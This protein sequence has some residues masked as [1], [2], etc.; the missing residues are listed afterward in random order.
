MDTS[1]LLSDLQ[2]AFGWCKKAAMQQGYPHNSRHSEL[3]TGRTV[4]SLR[5]ADFLSAIRVEPWGCC[6]PHPVWDEGVF[7]FYRQTSP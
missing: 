6:T 4:I 7:C 1:R 5:V 3:C 2:R